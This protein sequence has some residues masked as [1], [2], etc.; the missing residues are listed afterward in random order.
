MPDDKRAA[1]QFRVAYHSS[2]GRYFILRLIE[3][4]EAGLS[5]IAIRPILR[6]SGAGTPPLGI[7]QSRVPSLDVSHDRGFEV[8][9]AEHRPE[10]TSF[11]VA[12]G[13]AS[14]GFISRRCRRS[15]IEVAAAAVV[16]D[17]HDSGAFTRG[18]RVPASDPRQDLLGDVLTARQLPT[19]PRSPRCLA[20][21]P[22]NAARHHD[23]ELVRNRFVVRALISGRMCGASPGCQAIGRQPA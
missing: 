4:I 2:S 17:H 21:A 7:W 12:Q 19:H 13:K 23:R 8:R 9:A 5:S 22:K 15:D 1:V 18:K 14:P 3:P 16:Y 20:G 6:G 11:V 10:S